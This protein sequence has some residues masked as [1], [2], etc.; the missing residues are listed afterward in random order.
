MLLY[1]TNILINVHSAGF[2]SKLR[3]AFMQ[4]PVKVCCC[5]EVINTVVMSGAV[6]LSVVLVLVLDTT[7]SQTHYT[8]A[9]VGTRCAEFT[10]D[11]VGKCTDAV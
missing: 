9:A 5:R 3:E 1:F 8:R 2:H 6:Q 11:K 7:H 10:A 4:Q